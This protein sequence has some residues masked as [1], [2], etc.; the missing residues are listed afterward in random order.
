MIENNTFNVILMDIAMPK[1]SGHDIIESLYSHNLINDKLIVAL[2]ASSISDE[3][4]NMLEKKGVHSI[5][6]KP[7]DPDELLEY[8]SKI[9]K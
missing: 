4:K 9:K 6:K 5:L 8:L 3:E 2:T 7:I 1:F